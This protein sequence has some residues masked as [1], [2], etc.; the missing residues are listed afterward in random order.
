MASSSKTDWTKLAS[1]ADDDVD[2]SDQ[3]ELTDVFFAKAKLRLPPRVL[4]NAVVDGINRFIRDGL[5]PRG[6]LDQSRYESEEGLGQLKNDI[7]RAVA[8]G[9]KTSGVP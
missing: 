8:E 9:W 5:I 1:M 7:A 4:E 2:T 3:P 6:L